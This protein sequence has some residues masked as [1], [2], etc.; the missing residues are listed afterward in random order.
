MLLVCIHQSG[1]L[2]KEKPKTKISP[3][4]GDDIYA[5]KGT[6]TGMDPLKKAAHSHYS[7]CGGIRA[8]EENVGN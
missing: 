5:G 2:P 3:P 7:Q 1:K 4:T 6:E 8:L